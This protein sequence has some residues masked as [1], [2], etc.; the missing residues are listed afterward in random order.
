VPNKKVI[1]I[2]AKKND[3]FSEWFSQVVENAGLADYISAK[4]FIVLKP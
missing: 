3:D 2:T 4:E 1:G